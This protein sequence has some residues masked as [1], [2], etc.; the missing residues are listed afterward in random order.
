MPPRPE[1]SG[2]QSTLNGYL[3]G[4]SLNRAVP[5]R[6][7]IYLLVRRAIITGKLAPGAPINEVEIAA[8]LGTSRTPVREAVKK[9]SD[10]GLVNVFAQNGTFVAEIKRNQVEEAYIIRIAL[11]LESIRRAA[12]VITPEQIQDLEDIVHAHE[13]AFNRA[14][15]DEAILRDDDFHRY[16][17]EVNDLA[18]LWKV[19]DVSKAQ[20]DR[21]RL[22]TLPSEGAAQQTIAQHR[23]ILE[24]LRRNDVA[25]STA[26]L[27]THLE[28]SLHNTQTY[29]N[30]L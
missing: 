17:A 20:M 10:E 11:E 21:C 16:I 1:A 27:Q 3:S 9:V 5:L 4:V 12:S 26:A 15:F 22:L 25:A 13:V 23:I 6:D 19:V 18:M 2:D 14:R 24:A 8:K 30:S 7:Q 29:L 28:T